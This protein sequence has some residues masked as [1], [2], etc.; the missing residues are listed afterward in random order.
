MPK[1]ETRKGQIMSFGERWL[2]GQSTG[3]SY[4]SLEALDGDGAKE[5]ID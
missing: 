2:T 4:R 5:K 1:S 3:I